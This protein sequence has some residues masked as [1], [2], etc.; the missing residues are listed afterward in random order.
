MASF[1][2]LLLRNGLLSKR[3][4]A[5]HD[6]LRH[7]RSVEVLNVDLDVVQVVLIVHSWQQAPRDS[8]GR[9]GDIIEVV[10]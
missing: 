6:L 5:R 1:S 2:L 10:S 3:A 8:I 4:L 7:G 9:G